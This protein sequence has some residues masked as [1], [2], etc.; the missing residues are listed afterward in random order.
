MLPEAWAMLCN[1]TQEDGKMGVI[2][3]PVGLTTRNRLDENATT[4]VYGVGAFLLAGSEIMK[5]EKNNQKIKN[6][7]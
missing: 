5:L 7:E 6:D 3:S 2:S 1:Y 4:D